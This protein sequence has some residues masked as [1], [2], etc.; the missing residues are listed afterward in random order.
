[1]V[2][3]VNK[4]ELQFRVAYSLIRNHVQVQRNKGE[5]PSFM[6]FGGAVVNEESTGGNW[7]FEV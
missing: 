5:N 4:K 3:C 2:F 1:M 6:D 7:K